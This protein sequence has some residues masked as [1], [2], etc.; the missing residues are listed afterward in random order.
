MPKRLPHKL[1][2]KTFRYVPRVAVDI[3]V[4]NQK[5][6]IILTKRNIA[7]LK[8]LWHIPGSYIIKNEKITDCIERIAKD[9]IGIRISGKKAKLVGV[10][11]DMIADQRGHT[12][13]IIYEIG[14]EKALEFKPTSEAEEIKFFKKL[15]SDIGFNHQEILNTLDYY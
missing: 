9:E 6:E 2:L 1:F 10:S 3:L 15:P 14:I 13:D 8:G 7:P 5:S 12:I 4:K 11:E